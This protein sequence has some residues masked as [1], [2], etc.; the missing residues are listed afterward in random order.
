M[1]IIA[2]IAKE[3]SLKV[4]Q[5]K[6][7]V[8]L[9]DEGNTI[10]FIARY[11]KEVTGSIDD[12]VLRVLFERLTYLRSLEQQREKVRTSIEEQGK[13]T[14]ELLM[15]LTNAVTLTEIE[16]I[17]RPY[18]PKRK[19]RASIAKAKGLQPLADCIYAQ[20]K[21]LKNPIIMAEDYV[22]EELGV[23]SPDEALQGAKDIIAEIIS[24]DAQGRKR[25]RN[26]CKMNGEIAVKA[27]KDELDVYEMYGD[28]AE[29]INKMPG[30]RIL[31]IN[32]GE[33]EGYLKVAMKVDP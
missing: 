25:I 6:S 11:R 2:T 19:T 30:H 23:S 18:R 16:D 22:N 13:L 29:A 10:P 3:L 28:F 32:R 8:A 4:S 17:Y 26:V 24:D 31:A 21:D 27:A 1:D 9:I 33:K 7:A 15:A 14:E 12:Q 5:V 20:N